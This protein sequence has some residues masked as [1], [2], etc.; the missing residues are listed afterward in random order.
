MPYDILNQTRKHLLRTSEEQQMEA[1]EFYATPENGIIKI[2]EQ[3]RSKITAGVKVIL[4]NSMA[5]KTAN[6]V[7]S[8][9]K[10]SDMVLSPTLNTNGWRFDREEANAR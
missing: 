10:K 6:A 5:F 2:P 9:S 1:Y 4:L 3:Y 7:V 8:T